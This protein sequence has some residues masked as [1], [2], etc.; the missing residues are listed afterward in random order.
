[1]PTRSAPR[2]SAEALKFLRALKRNNRR[3]W[4]NAHRDD[5]EA[6]I[7]QPMFE[8]IERLCRRL[9]SSRRADRKPEDVDIASTATSGS[10]KQ[11]AYKTHRGEFPVG[12]PKHEGA[13]LLMSTDDVGSGTCARRRCRS[14]KRSADTSP[15]TT[16]VYAIVSRRRSGGS[17]AARRNG[18]ARPCFER[19]RSGESEIPSV[20]RGM[21][22]SS[23]VRDQPVLSGLA[24]VFRWFAVASFQTTAGAG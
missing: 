14:C 22:V 6:H 2:F 3:E 23:R 16:A 13:A 17:S 5:Y 12:L 9:A 15:P 7:R 1:M 10:G 11:G 19:S 24:D 4:F 18:S 21:R 8:I 20:H